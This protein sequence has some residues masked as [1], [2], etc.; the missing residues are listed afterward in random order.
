MRVLVTALCLALLGPLLAACERES[1]VTRDWTDMPSEHRPALWRIS[2]DGQSGYLFGAVHALPDRLHWYDD[3]IIAALDASKTLA[4][5]IDPSQEPQPVPDTF[6]AMG[7]TPGIPP[8]SQ[9]IDDQWQDEYAALA[10]TASLPD[11]A[12]TGRESW[13]AALSL[14]GIATSGLGV[15]RTYGVEAVLSQ[16]AYKRNM[17]IIALESAAEQF[18]YFDRLTEAQQLKMLEAVIAD[19]ATARNSYRTLL[20]NWLNGD[21][22]SLAETTKSGL[23]ATEPVRNA[24]LVQRNRAWIAEISGLVD[25]G[26]RPFVAVGAAH[27]AGQD[28]VQAMLVAEGF[29]IERVQ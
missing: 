20:T 16:Y 19:A 27:L 7:A 6:R 29:A 12:F 10:E 18:G 21:V 25:D 4:L 22:A 28:S 11:N 23:L 3:A 17:P 5:E 26:K 2:R 24:L 14:A 1:S 15:S 9:R 13:A 8:V